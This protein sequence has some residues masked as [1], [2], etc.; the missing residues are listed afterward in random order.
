MRAS[1]MALFAFVLCLSAVM[2]CS[3]QSQDE[4]AVTGLKI[5][6]VVV[7][8]V[9]TQY[10]TV[11]PIDANSIQADFSLDPTDSTVTA[12]ATIGFRV[13]S[14]EYKPLFAIPSAAVSVSYELDGAPYAA[15]EVN[16]VRLPTANGDS[17]KVLGT[18]LPAGNHVL[19]VRYSLTGKASLLSNYAD[20]IGQGL[21]AYVPCNPLLYDQFLFRGSAEVVN[22]ANAYRFY[23]NADTV[24]NTATNRWAF[25]HGSKKMNALAPYFHLLRESAVVGSAERT[26]QGANGPVLI[27][28]YRTD[29]TASNAGDVADL[30]VT[31]ME[32]FEQLLGPYAHGSKFVI[33]VIPGAGGMEYAGA[34]ITGY[35]ALKHEVFHSWFATGVFPRY[36]PDAWMDEALARWFDNSNPVSPLANTTPIR[37][38]GYSP[39]E[40]YFPG[41]AYNYG[42]KLISHLAWMA[43]GKDQFMR[44]LSEY[45]L[46]HRLKT[47]TTEMFRQYM[48]SKLQA[49][50]GDFFALYV[51]GSKPKTTE[52]PNELG[53][54][55]SRASASAEVRVVQSGPDVVHVK[56]Q[57]SGE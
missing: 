14:D 36:Y 48:E 22:T 49:S 21:Q 26:F 52:T 55:Q 25:D 3:G 45:Y 53:G 9:A 10:G 46:L 2:G 11:F 31:T 12:R 54:R 6:D 23:S 40:L 13:A 28:A 7:E 47:V 43:G 37:L 34:T 24:T 19:V 1:W 38:S 56:D 51:Y 57:C 20:T 33:Y 16:T 30:A 39:Y 27:Q 44:H 17:Y 50:L 29:S 18:T 4:A 42:S 41:D 5:D 32:R 8:P 15:S 35:S